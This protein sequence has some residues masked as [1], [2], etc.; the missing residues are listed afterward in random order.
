VET[1]IEGNQLKEEIDKLESQRKNKIE[2]EE[3]LL[4]TPYTKLD[5]KD[6]SPGLVLGEKEVRL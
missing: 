1:R 2:Q 4:G 5:G 3:I 6:I